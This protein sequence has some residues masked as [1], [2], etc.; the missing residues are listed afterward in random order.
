MND[1]QGHCLCGAV[2]F[3]AQIKN[4][5]T[6]ACHCGMCRRWAGSAYMA[7]EASDI[8]FDNT[9]CISIY[10]SSEWAQR[11]FCNR[12]GSSLYYQLT[13]DQAGKAGYFLSAGLL[14]DQSEL[15]FDHEVYVDHNPGWYS[16]SDPQDR[17]RMTE[18]D[19]LAQFGVEAE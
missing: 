19:V 1:K 2:S 12:C 18:A 5:R 13:G 16:F 6:G 14:D 8:R 3:S 7:V 15:K 9:D 4:N 17:H 11:A 10:P